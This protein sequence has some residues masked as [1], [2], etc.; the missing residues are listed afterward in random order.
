MI[1]VLITNDYGELA[2]MRIS[3][4]DGDVDEA[5][6]SVEFAVNRVGDTALFQRGIFRF[7]R[8]KFNVLALLKQALETL[9]EG[10]LKLD[11]TISPSDMER[12]QRGALRSLQ[13]WTSRLHHH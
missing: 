4:L 9:D 3:N 13:A 7:P 8:N 10:E 11:G 1:E 6:Y 12:R 2:R 5:S